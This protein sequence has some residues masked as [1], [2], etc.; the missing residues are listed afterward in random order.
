MDSSQVK[1]VSIDKNSQKDIA[2]LKEEEGESHQTEELRN[3]E[4]NEDKKTEEISVEPSSP[5]LP[6]AKGSYD[7]DFDNLD[8]VNPFVTKAAVQNSPVSSTG[9]NLDQSS[10]EEE[11]DD[12]ERKE[13]N[14]SLS[15]LQSVKDNPFIRLIESPAIKDKKQGQLLDA[16]VA[17]QS[18]DIFSQSFEDIDPFQPKK[19]LMNS[20]DPTQK[21]HCSDSN[22]D[23]AKNSNVKDTDENVDPFAT[24]TNVMNT[25]PKKK[26]DGIDGHFTT[27]LE[28]SQAE[29]MEVDDIAD[30]FVTK[31]KV[32]SSPGPMLETVGTDPF[33]TKSKI[34]NSPGMEHSEIE[35]SDHFATVSKVQNSP[36][37]DVVSENANPLPA[38]TKVENSFMETD[39][40]TFATKS[41]VANSPNA[42]EFNENINPF[43][44]KTNV[45]NS[46]ICKGANDEIDPFA[47]KSKVANSPAQQN[48]TEE[49]DPFATKSNVVNSPDGKEL[50]PFAT[51]SKVAN[52]PTTTNKQEE[53]DPFTTKSKVANSPLTATKPDNSDSF[54][55]N[56]KVATSPQVCEKPTE[57]KENSIKQ[58]EE[59][60]S[61]KLGKNEF[62]RDLMGSETSASPFSGLHASKFHNSS[63][64]LQDDP[65]KT[66]T[67]PAVSFLQCLKK[68]VGTRNY[69]I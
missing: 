57:N 48:A 59:S 13:N 23:D 16:I 51:K 52:S 20:P 30:P 18:D 49:I 8:E 10:K 27:E 53:T 14:T 63:S 12:A 60:T 21:T 28:N 11:R 41:K 67:G 61:I 33:Q 58:N 36:A 47:T 39:E 31:T 55:V 9:S 43:A 40:D 3:S 15:E 42:K 54:A 19:Q 44:T 17:E 24:K 64:T 29:P 32:A 62:E 26:D 25:P 37:N 22:P 2:V 46:P 69:L 56:S 4:G 50:D 38:Q 65:F 1:D 34:V 45:V 5:P 66:P 6:A 68:T 7:I 35:T